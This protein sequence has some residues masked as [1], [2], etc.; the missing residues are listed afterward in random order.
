[1]NHGITIKYENVFIELKFLVDL[2]SNFTP[3]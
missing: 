2:G 1:M 3:I